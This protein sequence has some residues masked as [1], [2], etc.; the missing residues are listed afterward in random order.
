M[1]NVTSTGFNRTC[2]VSDGLKFGSWPT[3]TGRGVGVW[4]CE[5][6]QVESWAKSSFPQASASWQAYSTCQTDLNYI[7]YY[8]RLQRTTL[9]FGPKISLSKEM[10]ENVRMTPRDSSYGVFLLHC[11]KASSLWRNGSWCLY[12]CLTVGGIYMCMLFAHTHH[13][14]YCFIF[15]RVMLI[16]TRYLWIIFLSAFLLRILHTWISR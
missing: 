2:E 8:R 9:P 7:L 16:Y 3:L 5:Q 15:T 6:C 1:T 10:I 12:V 13:M 4:I 14:L 11:N